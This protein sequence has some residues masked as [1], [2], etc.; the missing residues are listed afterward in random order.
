[1]RLLH[2]IETDYQAQP[3]RVRYFR[4]IFSSAKILVD[5]PIQ[6]ISLCGDSLAAI[7]WQ[8][9]I[10]FPNLY[11]SIDYHNLLISMMI[12]FQ[13]SVEHLMF[14]DCEITDFSEFFSIGDPILQLKF[15]ENRAKKGSC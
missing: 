9:T 8:N 2:S 15:V 12:L 5:P 11:H 7:F 10:L 4:H 3:T 13:V 14:G 6:L 1:M